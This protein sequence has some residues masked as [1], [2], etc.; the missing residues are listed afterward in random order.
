MPFI[1]VPVTGSGNSTIDQLQP[2]KYH[3][4]YKVIDEFLLDS[5]VIMI[6]VIILDGKSVKHGFYL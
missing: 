1:N 2:R 3:S 6:V 4:E 5:P